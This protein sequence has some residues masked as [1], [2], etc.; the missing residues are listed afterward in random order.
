MSTVAHDLRTPLTGL[1]GYLDLILEGRVDD[2]ATEREF[3]ERS[4]LIV[5]SM[6]DLVG[7]LLDISRLDA[8]NL[9]LDL[10]PFSVAEV[11]GRVLTAAGPARA[12]A[13]HRPRGPTCRRGCG[14]RRATA[15]RSSGS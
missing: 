9:R 2:R 6:G 7:D 11:G 13:R 4:R 10:R 5:D 8:G 3:M 1:S 15:A 14:R 12:P